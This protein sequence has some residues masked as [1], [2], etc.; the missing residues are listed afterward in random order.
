MQLPLAN[1]PREETIY[2][3]LLFNFTMVKTNVQA[4]AALHE[5]K[6]GLAQS[7][8]TTQMLE[9]KVNPRDMQR[10]E[11]LNEWIRSDNS[12]SSSDLSGFNNMQQRAL[13]NT[14]YSRPS[15]NR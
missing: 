5:T 9:G 1:L 10:L 6:Q 15:R 14:P 13:S 8:V 3:R 7:F 4:I 12:A 2:V 11:K